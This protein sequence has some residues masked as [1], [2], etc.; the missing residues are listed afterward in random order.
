[1]AFALV[2]EHG[3]FTA[4]RAQDDF[5]RVFFSAG[6]VG[7]FA[8]F[9]LAFD[10]DLGAFFQV[11]F[12]D[13]Y[14]VVVEHD[15]AVPF[16]FFF[17]FAGCFVVPA[18]GGGNGQVTKF[19]SGLRGPDFRVAAEVTYDD[20]FVY[21]ASHLSLSALKSV[22]CYLCPPTLKLRSALLRP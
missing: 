7:P 22:L 12:A 1:G 4:I 21:A 3:Q 14:D 5:G 13:A 18:F 2:I 6:L 8:G 9:K 15:D 16:G 11:V 19:R 10:K 17:A 20:H